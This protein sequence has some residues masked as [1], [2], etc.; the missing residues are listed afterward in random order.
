MKMKFY[1]TVGLNGKA[2]ALAIPGF[3][4]ATII[5][6]LLLTSV[7]VSACAQSNSCCHVTAET[8]EKPK[9]VSILGDSYSTFEGYIP[10]GNI[11]WYKPVPKEGRPTD[12]TDPNQTWWK[13]FIDSNGY[14]LEKN[15]SYSGATV[16]NT[17]YDGN[18][19][20]D[21][22]FVTRLTDLGNPD[23]ILVFGGT[24]DS[25]AGSPIGEYVWKDWSTTD[26]F[27]YR[28]AMAYML[29]K[30]QELHPAAEII[31]IINDELS[32]EIIESTESVC[33]HYG[34][35]Y[36]VTEN[37]SKMSGH[38]DKAGMIAISKQ[39]ERVLDL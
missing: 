23:M 37:I 33:D 35:K 26:L 17:G 22:S 5:I 25:W 24:N 8:V 9:K 19:Y 31:V 11:A 34:V 27:S 18:D 14:A 28:P 3:V 36:M 32:P 16:C 20:S 2:K 29:A 10:K 12:V 38:P 13:I 6:C 1:K 39:L 21:R 4:R 7:S 30:L 15:N